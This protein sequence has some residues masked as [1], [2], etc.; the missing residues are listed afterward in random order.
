[1]NI[2]TFSNPSSY[3]YNGKLATYFPDI[4]FGDGRNP[5]NE[6]LKNGELWMADPS[7]FNDPFDC[8]IPVSK[9]HSTN[10]NL[11][12]EETNEMFIQGLGIRCFVR[13]DKTPENDQ[14]MWSHYANKGNGICMIF[15]PEKDI[16]LFSP[17][18]VIGVEYVKQSPQLIHTNNIEL[19]TESNINFIKTKCY[20]FGLKGTQWAYENEIRLV[21]QCCLLIRE[22]LFESMN[23]ADQKYNPESVKLNFSNKL[24][25]FMQIPTVRN[26]DFKKES[27]V[28]IRFGDKMKDSRI[29]EIKDTLM[30]NGYGHVNCVKSCP[31]SKEFKIEYIKC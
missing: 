18:D 22:F 25:K 15:D 20:S 8:R 14:L 2:T 13:D 17:N 29:Q 21:K 30:K 1:M 4:N 16:E 9:I 23:K 24:A 7:G 3:T 11:T 27:L 31:N 19:W 10:Q 26:Y 5:I 6:T 28:E 12:I